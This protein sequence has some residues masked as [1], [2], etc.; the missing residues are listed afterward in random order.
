MDAAFCT[1]IAKN[2]LA[3]ARV[4]TRSLRRQHPDAPVYVLLVD[5]HDG[6]FD[7]TREPFTLTTLHEIGLP[8]PREFCFRYDV[9]E[10]STAVKP[11]FLRTLFARGYSK[12]VFLDPDIWVYRSLDRLLHALDSADVLLTPHLTAPLQ[13]E[14]RP[15]ERDIL[16][17]GAYN[18]GFLAVARSRQVDGFL[19]WWMDR[20]ETACLAE[21]ARGL[22]VDQKWM[23]LVPGFLDRVQVL[24]HPGYNVA[25]W[26]LRHR[27]LEGPPEDPLVNGEPLFFFH[28]SG[29]DPVKPTFLSRHEDRYLR[30]EE[31][32]L[33]GMVERYSAELLAHGHQA[34]RTWPYSHATFQNRRPV[35]REMRQL[36]R[37]LPPGRFP[38]PFRTTGPDTFAAWAVT[39]TGAR[40]GPRSPL[41][42]DF[43]TARTAVR[44]L[45][46]RIAGRLGIRNGEGA[47][48][49]HGLAPVAD[50][51]LA[52]RPD[53]RTAFTQPDG[54]VNRE[55]FLAWLATDGVTQHR[56]D[57]RWPRAW[58]K[59]G[60]GIMPRLIDL[61]DSRPE[62]R[63]RFPMAFVEEHDAPAFRSWLDEHG[64][65]AGLSRSERERARQ[66]FSDEPGRA[67]R[68]ILRDRPDVA[69]AFPDAFSWPG[70]PQFLAWLRDS[71]N[72]EYRIEEDWVLWF[73]RGREQ[74]LCL[75]LKHAY[76]ERSDWRQRHPAAFSTVGS[77]RFLRWLKEEGQPR[78]AG[79]DVSALSRLCVLAPLAPLEELRLLCTADPELRH[80]FP[81]AFEDAQESAALLGWLRGEGA[82]KLAID[83]AWLGR[84]ESEARAAG[85]VPLSTRVVGYLCTES[86]MGELSRATARALQAVSVPVATVDL[87]DAPQRQADR[88]LAATAADRPDG[89]TIVHV[90]A[91]EVARLRRRLDAW[92]A[93]GPVIG[94][95]A[96]EIE[97]VP[98]SWSE[99]AELFEEIWTCSRHSAAAIA[100][101]VRAP[102]QA[103]WPAV[104]VAAPAEV[105]REDLGLDPEAFLFF[106][107]YDVLSETER[108]N[109]A[110]LIEAFR[111][112]FRGDDRVGL[113]LKTTNGALRPDELCRVVDAAKGLPVTIL[114]RYLSRREVLG[115]MRTCD[116]YVSLHRAEGF[117]FTL[118]EAMM[119]GRPVVAT[120][121]SGNTDFMTPWNSFPVPYRLVEAGSSFG[122]YAQG[123]LW[124]EPDRAAAADLMR[125][126]YRDREA[127]GE[128]ARRGRA[129]VE[130]QLSAEACGRRLANRLL[131]ITRSGPDGARRSPETRAEARP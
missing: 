58:R 104:S 25:Y 13:D 50:A 34:C 109:P 121:Y 94:Y 4:L 53:V 81:R 80:R 19:E 47:A 88:S 108:K 67:V 77:G 105:R 84:L 103:L 91:P 55:A 115:L 122:P 38:D 90:N 43:R 36:F 20:C 120:H 15:A 73:A 18:L 114:D 107:A 83:S 21:P 28:F 95:W 46:G 96:W 102:V 126:V 16:L 66:L 100:G 29:L 51:I 7:P 87:G 111:E 68:A 60:P 39:P 124:A 17:S 79:F 48:C 2:Y 64:T 131:R 129:D 125:R 82:E 116:A 97:N 113:L 54:E 130:R 127:A 59:R 41:N 3:Y 35:S 112:A 44:A 9:L 71:G 45:M 62:L 76:D 118:A 75:R 69:A 119:L 1:I 56:L 99:A 40:R 110:G 24:R 78:E 27:R 26:N 11:Y 74:H 42:G 37:A 89:F 10:L 5:E 101:A 23:D 63:R 92:R 128:V 52:N 98:P 33:A 123:S 22:F 32:P 49:P 31:E 6:F 72:K 30:L 65:E 93:D 85:L 70:D 106:F 12:L 14:H 8:R 117:G 86:G 61:Y 57:P